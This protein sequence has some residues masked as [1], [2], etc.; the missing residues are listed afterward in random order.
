MRAR[1]LDFGTLL[2]CARTVHLIDDPF[3]R[4]TNRRIPVLRESYWWFYCAAPFLMKS[5]KRLPTTKFFCVN[6][7]AKTR[8]RLTNGLQVVERYQYLG[9]FDHTEA[10]DTAKKALLGIPAVKRPGE[11]LSS[12]E[13]RSRDRSYSTAVLC[14]DPLKNFTVR[15]RNVNF[16]HKSTDRPVA[17]CALAPRAVRETYRSLSIKQ[18]GDVFCGEPLGHSLMVRGRCAHCKRRRYL[19]EIKQHPE[20]LEWRREVRLN[21]PSRHQSATSKEIT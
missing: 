11:T 14:S 16:E 17:R 12:R 1:R 19:I 5:A 3:S 6:F 7:F 13:L 8:S 15:V 4:H 20:I 21:A 18:A 2:S 10:P 9:S